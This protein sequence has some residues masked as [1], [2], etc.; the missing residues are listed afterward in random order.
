M[1]HDLAIAPQMAKLRRSKRK[2]RHSRGTGQAAL[3]VVQQSCVVTAAAQREGMLALVKVPKAS[4]AH[5]P[6]GIVRQSSNQV[7]MPSV[8]VARDSDIATEP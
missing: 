4:R 1:L 3:P 5:Q 7:H 6:E 2:A 8:K